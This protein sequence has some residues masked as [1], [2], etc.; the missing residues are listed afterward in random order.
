MRTTI[1]D[2]KS[3]T[4]RAFS[5]QTLLWTRFIDLKRQKSYLQNTCGNAGVNND[6]NECFG[7]VA[8][9][10]GPFDWAI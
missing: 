3:N 2:A 1:I 8:V 6:K 4:L 10:W 5:E 9:S 7:A